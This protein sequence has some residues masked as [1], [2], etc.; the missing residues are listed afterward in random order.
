MH[1]YMLNGN[2]DKTICLCACVYIYV[3][4]CGSFYV[5]NISMLLVCGCIDEYKYKYICVFHRIC[6]NVCV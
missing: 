5:C 4:I 2:I 6:K 1:V 3:H